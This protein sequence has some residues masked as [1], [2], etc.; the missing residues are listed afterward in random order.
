M[1]CCPRL[2]PITHS[3]NQ[4]EVSLHGDAGLVIVERKKHFR[5]SNQSRLS[6]RAGVDSVH[7]VGGV[8][9]RRR[10]LNSILIKRIAQSSFSLIEVPKQRR[11][12]FFF[13]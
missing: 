12:G 7:S 6:A 13:N 9:R 10:H 11:K 5:E 2:P 3:I 1:A 8:C 4:I